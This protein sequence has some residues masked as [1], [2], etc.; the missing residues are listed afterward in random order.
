MFDSILNGSV[1]L[2]LGIMA[3]CTIT[4]LII[5][6]LIAYV[7][8]FDEM[9]SRQFVMTLV[10]LPT[11][12]QMVIMMVNGNLGTSVAVLGT[13]G[14]VRFRS[15]PGSSKDICFIFFAMAIGL[16]TGMGYIGFAIVIAVVVSLII[17]ILGKSSFI[18]IDPA[19][20]DLHITIPENLDY[21][22]IFNDLFE[23]YTIKAELERVKTTHLGSMYELRY[24]IILKEVQKEKEFLDELRCRNGNLTIVSGRIQN[25]Q[26]EL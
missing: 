7:Y 25:V 3:I 8:K 14:L 17:L 22:E 23:R 1:S 12:V 21:T 26:E 5:G 15:L 16:A 9:Y 13:F 2:T 11:L 10:V 19:K 4:S 6:V 20:R 18:R 24:V